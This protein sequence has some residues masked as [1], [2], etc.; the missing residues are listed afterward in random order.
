MT[1]FYLTI[2]HWLS[3]ILH[4][5]WT[6]EVWKFIFKKLKEEENYSWCNT[7]LFLVGWCL[8]SI[9]FILGRMGDFLAL[10]NNTK[11][12]WIKHWKNKTFY[13]RKYTWI[14]VFR[15]L[16]IWRKFFFFQSK[17]KFTDLFR[18]FFCLSE[19]WSVWKDLCEKF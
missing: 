11:W 7:L 9:N 18:I 19:H 3:F 14:L 16:R 5:L 8:V 2:Q 10:G 6:R 1:L 13:S 17:V 4:I 12:R 15:I